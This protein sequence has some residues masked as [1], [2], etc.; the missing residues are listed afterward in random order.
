MNDNFIRYEYEKV[1]NQLYPSR[2]IYTGHG[3]EDGIFEVRFSRNN[4][5]RADK[6]FSYATGFLV[7]TKYLIN[8]I[9]VYAN[10]KL[11]GKYEL[12]FASI[13]PLVRN[14]LGSIQETGYSE[15]GSETKLP[16]ETFEYTPSSVSWQETNLYIPPVY[17]VTYPY[18]NGD[19]LKYYQKDFLWDF[20]G[21]GLVDYFNGSAN[22]NPDA[23]VLYVNDGK[24]GWTLKAKKDH[25]V[26]PYKLP[27][28][29]AKPTDFNGDT[30][31]DIAS[32]WMNPYSYPKTLD[33]RIYFGDGSTTSNAL[34]V[35]MSEQIY[36]YG[37]SMADLNGDG[38]P[39]M[40]QKML[41]IDNNGTNYFI[42]GTCLNEN[43][44][45]CKLTSL[46]E[47]PQHLIYIDN[48]GYQYPRSG[49]VEDCNN[50]GLADFSN[51]NKSWLNDGKGGW[52]TP[53]SDQ[54]CSFTPPDGIF[55]AFSGY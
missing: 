36:D 12:G 40:I 49:Y 20:S 22:S 26:Y 9:E 46:W 34:E 38:L 15:N 17:F 43:G 54:L 14:T 3:Q 10:G 18:E 5:I 8:R 24:G 29:A 13:D 47:A 50:D 21:D 11:R 27:E 52:L 37:A 35:A 25:Y 31:L 39:D 4:T 42:K 32:S 45:K 48:I 1:D 6:H 51:L 28:V 53:K 7:E 2:I 16:A 23:K 19:P 44:N 33:S 55:Y 41:Q 30:V